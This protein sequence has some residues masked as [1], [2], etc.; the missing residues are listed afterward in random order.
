MLFLWCHPSD[1]RIGA[2]SWLKQHSWGALWGLNS[3]VVKINSGLV[4]PLILSMICRG[5]AA[6][7]E[8]AGI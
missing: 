7:E 3:E 6:T 8:E 5:T 1:H 2:V 4:V